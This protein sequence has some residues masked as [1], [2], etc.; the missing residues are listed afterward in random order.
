MYHRPD[1]P[2]ANCPKETV[3]SLYSTT[4]G[5]S[6]AYDDTHASVGGANPV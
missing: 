5:L 4:T 1:A 2:L 6:S 3:A